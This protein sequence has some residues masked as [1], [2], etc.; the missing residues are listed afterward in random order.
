[1]KQLAILIIAIFWMSVSAFGQLTIDACQEMARK[2]FPLI[3]Q[4]RLIE[5]TEEYNISNAKKG[6]L[7]QGSLSLNGS[8]ADIRSDMLKS[9]LGSNN[10]DTKV[11]YA[12]ASV[13]QTVWDGGAINAQKDI[14]KASSDVDKQ[15]VEVQIY[16]LRDR[17]NQL[18]FGVLLLKEQL[19]QNTSL[20]K[21][22]Q[23]NYDKIKAYISGGVANSSDLDEVRVEQLKNVQRRDEL[24]ATLKAYCAMLSAMTGDANIASQ[25]FVKPEMRLNSL[26]ASVN[27]PELQLYNVQKNY[28]DSQ[29]KYYKS[30]NMP[31]VG[32]SMTG[33]YAKIWNDRFS[34]P[35]LGFFMGGIG[36]SWNFGNLYSYKNNVRKME[37][38]KQYIDIQRETF[39]YN[40]NLD[41]TQKLN[42]IEKFQKQIKSDDEI[43]LLRNSIRKKAEV[44]IT[45]GTLSVTDLLTKLNDEDLAEQDKILHEIQLLMAFYNYKNLTNN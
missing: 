10:L 23:I 43:I 2:N 32:L 5:K 40:N 19:T 42:E 35:T 6:Y 8:Y 28:Y 7:P 1:M 25:T 41:A 27:R 26:N 21:E 30:N 18:F 13:K 12:M 33:A 38:N 36:L 39:L 29:I 24:N 44:K 9:F 17:V 16:A 11:G 3:K 4:Y 20:D 37:I 15:N 22:L 31:K 14:A 34:N 45:N